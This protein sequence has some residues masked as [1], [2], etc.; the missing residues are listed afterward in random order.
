MFV[1]PVPCRISGSSAESIR[2]AHALLVPGVVAGPSACVFWEYAYQLPASEAPG[3]CWLRFQTP[4]PRPVPRVGP[5]NPQFSREC[6][7][8]S[9][10]RTTVQDGSRGE[11]GDLE[12]GS[13]TYWSGDWHRHFML[14]LCVLICQVERTPTLQ[15]WREN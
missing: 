4:G 9:H 1:Q 5:R 15:G 10:V 13:A 3:V 6:G 12:L 14:R 2:G 8:H 11:T 7:A